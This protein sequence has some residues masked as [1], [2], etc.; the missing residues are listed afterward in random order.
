M[1]RGTGVSLPTS[2]RVLVASLI[3]GKSVRVADMLAFINRFADKPLAW[4]ALI[5]ALLALIVR[6][7]E[8]VYEVWKE[9]P[10][11]HA[12]SQQTGP[13]PTSRFLAVQILLVMLIF[14][15]H[16]RAVAS[17]LPRKNQGNFPWPL[18]RAPRIRPLPLNLRHRGSE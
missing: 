10:G 17:I 15:R 8:R 14:M 11:P 16:R 12:A 3:L 2:T 4:K 5:Y 18:A 7:V 1:I 13:M 9:A 6:Y